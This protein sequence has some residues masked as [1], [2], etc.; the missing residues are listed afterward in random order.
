MSDYSVVQKLLHEI[1]EP[2]A[3]FLEKYLPRIR[4]DWWYSCVVPALPEFMQQTAQKD[5]LKALDTAAL[6]KVFSKN[7]E[8]LRPLA[9]LEFV[10]LN[11][12][13]E[14]QTIRNRWA[15]P[16][17][18]GYI[19]DD[20][21]ER[22]LDTLR[23]LCIGIKADEEFVNHIAQTRNELIDSRYKSVSETKTPSV[24]PVVEKIS[25]IQMGTLIS[26]ISKPEEKAPVIK[27]ITTGNEPK[28][29]VYL[30]GKYVTWYHSQIKVVT[31]T[32]EQKT[33]SLDDFNAYLTATQLKNPNSDSLFSLNSAKIDIIPHQFR[34]VLKFIRADRPRL[35]IADGVGVG[36]TIEAGLILKELEARNDISSVLIICPKPLVSEQ[37]WED[38]MKHKFGE[39]FVALNG[40]S[41]RQAIKEA[42][43][44]TWDMNKY[45]K[46]IVPY[47]LFTEDKLWDTK[48]HAGL[49]E[50]ENPPKF[51]LVIVDEAHHIRNSDTFAYKA[52]KYF[53]DNAEAAVLLTATPIQIGEEDLFTLLNLI[54]PDLVPDFNT[55]QQMSA[56]NPLI[57]AAIAEIRGQRV[58]WLKRSKAKLEEAAKTG[59]GQI[60]YPQNPIY[61][62]S[63]K[64]LS[65]NDLSDEERI[66]LLTDV[67]SLHSFSYIINRTRRR[68]IDSGYAS[69][70]SQ[71]LETPFTPEQ[72][73]VYDEVIRIQ[74]EIF[75]LIQ[76][77][78]PA[79]FMINTLH[80]RAA[81]CLPGL[82]P[83]LEHILKRNLIR[84]DFLEAGLFD[85]SEIDFEEITN[86]IEVLLRRAKALP[87]V[88]NKYDTL[89]KILDE[90]KCQ[91]P[92]KVMLFSTFRHT[93][94]YL[95]E[96]LSHDKYRIGIIHGDVKDEDR[97]Y[98]RDRFKRPADDPEAID[99]LLFSEV[100]CE[101]LDYQFCDCM[102][103][104][105]LPWNP[106]KI[107]Q[108]IGRIDRTGQKSETVSIF[109]LITPE[110]VDADIYIRCLSRIGVFEKAIG[111]NEEIL[112]A[113]A[114]EMTSIGDNFKLSEEERAKR[115]SQ[116]ADN[117]IRKYLESEKLADEQAELFGV[118]LSSAQLSKELDDATSFWLSPVCL[119]N[120]I[121]NYLKK[122]LNSDTEFIVGS[123][124]S[125]KLRLSAENR[126]IMKKDYNNLNPKPEY[127]RWKRWLD[128]RDHDK[129]PY[130]SVCFDSKLSVD[131][132]GDLITPTHPIVRQALTNLSWDDDIS[133]SICVVDNDVP[134]GNYP[135]AVYLW[136]YSGQ[137]KSQKI[138]PIAENSLIS[139]KLISY[140]KR[141][142]SS[143][144]VVSLDAAQ[145]NIL[146]DIQYNLWMKERDEHKRKN[147]EA[148]H[149]KMETLKHSYHIREEGIKKVISNAKDSNI[150]RMKTD[151]LKNVS[152]E[153]DLRLKDL[154]DSESTADV[155]SRL[156][157][158]GL[159]EVRHG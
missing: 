85:F 23:R 1:A 39:L 88:D 143:E 102:I 12:L 113:I 37:K 2:V 134:E 84:E 66:T 15:H 152:T 3:S 55:F 54:R 52:V 28:Y 122:R 57:N 83:F 144:E 71:T 22:D 130:Y 110:T 139:E 75:K 82:I 120:L 47:S 61:V 53:I 92:N 146:E 151:E 133:T 132:V 14:A 18:N 7:W 105:D 97:Q 138:I 155:E 149:Y 87:P 24:E 140:L 58:G 108:R 117:K 11:Y 78:T 51:D 44:D 100:G 59:W 93:L 20:D 46:I 145:Q 79:A 107:E 56:P 126:H 27:I 81:S 135:F 106:M 9:Q 157:G 29:T 5:N 41:F 115:L 118:S 33:V 114:T 69:R 67:E 64:K 68:D 17:A 128:G 74:T 142:N 36:K 65:N 153:K 6:L 80:R 25:E 70:K 16:P 63:I 99:I 13:K 141:G 48:K 116:L 30:N 103:N 91:K 127:S 136:D 96:K 35:L 121:R 10:H 76:P 98:L 50:L 148:I 111:G 38:E 4:S 77:E 156:V 31:E 60:V 95:A 21:V 94:N 159:V 62:D 147:T 73:E 109:N 137:F 119:E 26:L 123:E 112:G 42:S 40:E 131:G 104:Y 8:K 158:Y 43:R 150:I 90:K 86:D 124:K 72:K 34:P 19:S 125:K 49:L 45:G 32:S 101:G 89:V 154:L 129:S